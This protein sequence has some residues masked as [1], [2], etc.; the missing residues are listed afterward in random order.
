MPQKG[1]QVR[2][3]H[4]RY[5]PEFRSEAARLMREGGRNPEELAKELGCPG[6]VIRN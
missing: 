4:T 3:G 6:Q 2:K 1:V 5:P